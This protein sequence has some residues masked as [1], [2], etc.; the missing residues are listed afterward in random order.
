MSVLNEQAEVNTRI[1]PNKSLTFQ[2]RKRKF[3]KLE[4]QE[5]SKQLLPNQIRRVLRTAP[6]QWT[7]FSKI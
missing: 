4:K 3:S 1:C 7:D 2:G 6:R 5:N